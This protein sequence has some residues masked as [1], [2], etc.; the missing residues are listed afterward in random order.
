MRTLDIQEVEMVSGGLNINLGNFGTTGLTSGLDIG[1]GISG[2]LNVIPGVP[3][4][5]LGGL[6]G[7]AGMLVGTIMDMIF[8]TAKY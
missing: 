2:I 5:N 4:I 1:N 6:L 3:T 8:P 7:G